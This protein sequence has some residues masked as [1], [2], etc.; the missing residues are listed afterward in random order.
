MIYKQHFEDYHCLCFA[1]ARACFYTG[2]GTTDADEVAREVGDILPKL[3]DGARTTAEEFIF[4]SFI[5]E[6]PETPE[7]NASQKI[8]RLKKTLCNK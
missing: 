3:I 5:E 1:R 6:K 4:T 7:S 8:A 2:L